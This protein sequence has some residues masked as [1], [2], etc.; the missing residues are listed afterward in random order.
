MEDKKQEN[1]QEKPVETL[2][3]QRIR[4]ELER[5]R[6]ETRTIKPPE[7]AIDSD[8][9][10][11]IN[12]ALMDF[13]NI[14]SEDWE[15]YRNK[16]SVVREWAEITARSKEK[17]EILQA[18]KYLEDKVISRGLTDNRLNSLYKW[19]RL[20]LDQQRIEKEKELYQK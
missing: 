18:I 15:T 4:E 9:Y 17:V 11:A 8:K 1:S 20:D 5:S 14:K 6:R 16:L 2:R 7:T 12:M 13:L 3:Q 19:I 10:D